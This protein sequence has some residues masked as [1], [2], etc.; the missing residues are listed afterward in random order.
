MENFFEN[1]DMIHS[2]SRQN[3]I[4]DGLLIVVP[5]KLAREIGFTVP[6][7]IILEVWESCIAWSD[8]DSKRQTP[9]DQVGRMWD[10]LTM[11]RFAAKAGGGRDTVMFSVACVPRDGKTKHPKKLSLK[12]VIG[13]GDNMEPVITVMLPGED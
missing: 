3:M 11:L 13:P 2:Y 9:Q 7:G 10:L 1:A 12:A 6:V 8:E 4:D 5:E